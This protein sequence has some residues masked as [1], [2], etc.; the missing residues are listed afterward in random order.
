MDSRV[1]K[2]ALEF[3]DWD[4]LC[5][6]HCGGQGAIH[7]GFFENIFKVR[8]LSRTARGNEWHITNLSDTFELLCVVAASN[9]VLVH[10]VEN[11]FTCPTILDF[12]DPFQ[13]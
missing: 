9:P 5:V 1:N 6:K 4:L 7:A 2:V 12:S 3:W 10:A 8:H 13:C 11:D